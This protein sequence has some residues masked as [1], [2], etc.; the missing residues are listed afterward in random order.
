MRAHLQQSSAVKLD[1]K[2]QSHA[3]QTLAYLNTEAVHFHKGGYFNEAVLAYGRLLNRA[4]A[5]NLTH[6]E[7]YSCYNNRAAAYLKLQK[8]EEALQD[9][10]S[11][12][13]LAKAALKRSACSEQKTER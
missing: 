6:A 12:R 10:E 2:A 8:Y 1:E 9:A 4:R 5:N 13:K 3:H 7:M 11:A